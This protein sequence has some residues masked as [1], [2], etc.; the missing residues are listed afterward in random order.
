M[1]LVSDFMGLG[2]VSQS[3]GLVV[4]SNQSLN[5]GLCLARNYSQLKTTRPDEGVKGK[6]ENRGMKKA[7]GRW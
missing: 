6:N 3:Q 4:H 2:L 1:M 7:L 5:K